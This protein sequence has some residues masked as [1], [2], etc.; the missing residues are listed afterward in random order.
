M[1]IRFEWTP[2]ISVG[3]DH[4]DAQHKELLS[5]INKLFE[6]VVSGDTSAQVKDVLSFL[7]DYIYEHFSYEE[8]YM[9]Q[10]QYPD[11]KQHIQ[12]HRGFMKQYDSLKERLVKQGSNKELVQDIEVYLGG[13]WIRHIGVED[14]KYAVWIGEH[15]V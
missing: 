8:E 12:I 9:T 11:I 7:D 10:H 1:S 13:W 3:D 4:I 15:K 5:Q 6:V 14:K 2:D